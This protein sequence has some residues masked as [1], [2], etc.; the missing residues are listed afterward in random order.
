MAVRSTATGAAVTLGVLSLPGLSASAAQAPPE[1]V[2]REPSGPMQVTPDC[3][4]PAYDRPV[5]DSET[6]QT[7]PVPHRKVSGHFEGTAVRFNFYFPAKN[8]WDG[9]FFQLVYPLQ[10]E[11]ATAEN[12]GF[13]AD[14]GAYT[15][16]TSGTPGYRADAAAAKFSRTVAARYYRSTRRIHGYVHGGSGGS[17]QTIGAM[18]NTTGVWQGAVPFIPGVPTSI[19]NNF[20][21]RAFARLVLRDKA[22]RIA[23]A[24][25]PGGSGDPYTGLT[26]TERAVLT[27]VTKMGVP[28]RAW[29]NH[30]YVL[31]LDDPQGLLGFAAQVQRLDPAYADDFWSRPGHLGTERSP[32]GD[33]VRAAKIDHSAT[34]T[35]VDR[36][37]QDTP[38]RLA[39]D[40]VPANPAATAL[41]FT[42]YQADGTTRIGTL[43]GT[44]DPA[45]KTFTIGAG[46][47]PEVL[48]ALGAGGRLRMDNRWS[49]ALLTYHRHQ[50]PQRPGFSAWDQFRGA[51]G[52]PR[53]PQRGIEAGPAISTGVSGG[54][55]HTGKVTGKVIMVVN[56]LDTDAFPWHA[57]W[58]GTQVKQAMGE[59]YDGTFR[60]LYNDNAD[61]IGAHLT[62]LVDYGGIL[63]QALRDVSAW[64]ERGVAPPRSTRYR[65]ADGQVSVPDDAA[66]RRG[67]QP[68][69][70]LTAGGAHRAEVRAGRPVTFTAKVQVPPGTGDVVATEWDLAGT[71]TFTP[72][73]FGAP[74]PS[75]Q[76]RRTFTYTKPG[77]YFAA[78]RVSAQREGDTGTPYA[79]VQNLERVR[80]VVR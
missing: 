59:R 14:S 15:V 79:R 3:V 69:V 18:E 23:D 33:L 74:R 72:S 6:D 27:E 22:P 60:V 66:Q 38:T 8:R 2:Q 32:L 1:C 44:L 20:F 11:N 71:G 51:D 62:G 68:V 36:D 30:R 37:A 55:T 25:R 64:A 42:A 73:R 28:L 56:L 78:L 67:V 49:L 13:G 39:L 61:H 54:G 57:D 75:V 16:Q 77:T 52:R 4:D 70:D 17:Y 63:Q 65:V 21:V 76:V 10:D 58:Y 12:I 40:S 26:A 80:I 50:V 19:P 35:R 29:Q 47:A 48:D 41:G 5:I 7:A 31:G 34:I 45:T 24:V 53:Y 43:T 9:R 46:N